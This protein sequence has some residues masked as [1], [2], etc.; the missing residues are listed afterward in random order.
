MDGL[1]LNLNKFPNNFRLFEIVRVIMSPALFVQSIN[2]VLFTAFVMLTIEQNIQQ[3][4]PA[5]FFCFMSFFTQSMT[6]FVTYRTAETFTEHSLRFGHII[7][8]SNWYELPIQQQKMLKFTIE[9]AQKSFVFK[10]SAIFYVNMEL[11]ANV[12]QSM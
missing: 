7:Q 3:I 1:G 10:G 9:R 12:S 2:F 8:E 5:T 6:N 11:F 4:T